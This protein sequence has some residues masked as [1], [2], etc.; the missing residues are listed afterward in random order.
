MKERASLRDFK[1]FC[2][3]YFCNEH[4]QIID[5]SD[6]TVSYIDKIWYAFYPPTRESTLERFE[7]LFKLRAFFYA[8]LTPEERK[9]CNEKLSRLFLFT[10]K[11][12]RENPLTKEARE[13]EHVS[14]I[15]PLH[16]F[17]RAY[18]DYGDVTIEK[19]P[20]FLLSESAFDIPVLKEIHA[21]V[22]RISETDMHQLHLA[23]YT[24][25]DVVKYL[26][27]NRHADHEKDHPYY[28][29][30][31]PHA[32]AIENIVS[33]TIHWKQTGRAVR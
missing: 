9:G 29:P 31:L 21:D 3:E 23:G 20:D 28:V 16:H 7:K 19:L 18:I 8:E 32:R 24:L 27:V 17:T 4:L 2:R 10:G 13:D 12:A 15:L 30:G 14:N 33:S 26:L 25:F 1:A 6:C 22:A 11:P 5:L